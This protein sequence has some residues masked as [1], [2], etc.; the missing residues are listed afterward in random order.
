MRA[1]RRKILSGLSVG[2]A[3]LFARPLLRNAFGQTKATKPARLLVICM[4]NC[5]IKARWAPTGGRNPL[6]GTGTA[7]DFKWGFCNEPLEKVRQYVTLIDGLDHKKVGGDPHGSGFIRYTT[8]G[9]IRAGE[10]AKDPG[11]GRLPGDGN[12][13]VLPS[14]DQLFLKKSPILG[15]PGLAMQN[16]LQLAI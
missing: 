7:T 10:A 4:P 13:P 14:V 8:G 15:D 5:S 1:T 2:A 9:T 6:D 16:G 11:A 3:T 12:L